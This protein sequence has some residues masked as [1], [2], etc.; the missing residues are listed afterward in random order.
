MDRT[1]ELNIA[2]ACKILILE[3]IENDSKQCKC[4]ISDDNIDIECHFSFD[5]EYDEE[6]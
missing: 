5:I 1:K 6:E 3:C 2:N 4:T